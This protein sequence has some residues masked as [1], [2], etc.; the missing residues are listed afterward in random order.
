MCWRV[1]VNLQDHADMNESGGHEQNDHA[2]KVIMVLER[3]RDCII[4][5]AEKIYTFKD[6][7]VD[8]ISLAKPNNSKPKGRT[9]KEIEQKVIKLGEKRY[10]ENEHEM[11]EVWY[12]RWSQ[13]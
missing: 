8:G 9:M 7:A 11:P 10:K 5:C 2:R 6:F 13:Q 1:H 12:C 4:L 3:M